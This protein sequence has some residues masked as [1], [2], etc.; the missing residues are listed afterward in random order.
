M[1]NHIRADIK[2]KLSLRTEMTDSDVQTIRDA[3]RDDLPM[4]RSANWAEIA[5]P[6]RIGAALLRERILRE[7]C[8]GKKQKS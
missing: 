7:M 4:K 5:L 1:N 8:H 2:N 3:A 6:P